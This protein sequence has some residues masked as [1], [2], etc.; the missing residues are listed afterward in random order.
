M[1]SRC[2]EFGW[3]A[4]DHDR[5]SRFALALG[6][7]LFSRRRVV[8]E[9]SLAVAVVASPWNGSFPKLISNT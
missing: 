5:R 1:K 7:A 9:V 6:Q 2:W 3:P 4:S 8:P